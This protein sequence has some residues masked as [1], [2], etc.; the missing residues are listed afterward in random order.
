M[1]YFLM[2]FLSLVESS[3]LAFIILSEG[4]SLQLPGRFPTPWGRFFLILSLRFLNL[5]FSF[6]TRFRHRDK[7]PV[8]GG[9][10][11]I[12]LFRLQVSFAKMVII[13]VQY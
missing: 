2:A 10:L 11:H 6:F 12:T 13:L 9:S 7:P 1:V 5:S 8:T 3:F 4:A